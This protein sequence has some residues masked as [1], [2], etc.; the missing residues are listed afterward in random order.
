MQQALETAISKVKHSSMQLQ[1]KQL[2]CYTGSGNKTYKT[3]SPQTN[4]KVL[5]D[6]KYYT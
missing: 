1:S 3:K 5:F 2:E 6:L 4:Y